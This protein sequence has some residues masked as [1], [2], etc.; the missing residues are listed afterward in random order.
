MNGRCM[1]AKDGSPIGR[2][3]GGFDFNDVSQIRDIYKCSTNISPPPPSPSPPPPPPNPS[4]PPKPPS[5]PR[6]PRIANI[7][8]HRFLPAHR[9]YRVRW[10]RHKWN[11]RK[12][13]GSRFG[14]SARAGPRVGLHELGEQDGDGAVAAELDAPAVPEENALDDRE[15]VDEEIYSEADV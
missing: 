3:T 6:V 7:R 10:N 8:R 2:R 4:P 5:P 15:G 1:R 14:L 13:G 11:W 9:P 12:R